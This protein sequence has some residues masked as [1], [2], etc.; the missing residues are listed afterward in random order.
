ML[1]QPMHGLAACGEGHDGRPT[2]VPLEDRAAEV[3][4]ATRSWSYGF[5]TY[6]SST[7]Q[8]GPVALTLYVGQFPNVA[9]MPVVSAR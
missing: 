6:Q 7:F 4:R 1:H 8:V 9:L 2:G 5:L 3:T